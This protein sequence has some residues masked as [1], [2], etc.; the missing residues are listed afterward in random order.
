MKR[1]LIV[2]RRYCQRRREK[3]ASNL[4]IFLSR[5]VFVWIRQKRDWTPIELFFIASISVMMIRNHWSI[6]ASD[7]CHGDERLNFF[8]SDPRRNWNKSCHGL[9]RS[10]DRATTKTLWRK[11]IHSRLKQAF[12]VL[13]NDGGEFQKNFLF[14]L[15]EPSSRCFLFFLFLLYVGKVFTRI[16]LT[17]CGKRMSIAC[18]CCVASGCKCRL[19]CSLSIAFPAL[20]ALITW[21]RVSRE[22]LIAFLLVLTC[23]GWTSSCCTLCGGC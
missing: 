17:Y 19:H 2:S 4:I 3:H 11:T 16:S 21:K 13:I 14:V 5:K 8:M 7:A 6:I 18:F 1:F 15:S 20:N 9:L 23:F 22:L 10:L 12:V